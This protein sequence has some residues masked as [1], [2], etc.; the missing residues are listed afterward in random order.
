MAATYP[1]LLATGFTDQGR[2]DPFDLYGGESDI[3]T[4][5]GQA[6]DGQ[7]IRQFEVLMRNADGKL[8]PFTTA[9]V[10]A[11]GAITVGG[12]PTAADTVTINGV[13]ITFRTTLTGT[14]DECLIGADTTATAANLVTVINNG[15]TRFNVSASSVGTVVTLVAE[16]VG[17]AGNSV[18]LV[19]GVTSIGFTVSGATLTGASATEGTLTNNAIGIAGQPVGASTPGG[20]FPYFTGGV[21]NHQ[22]LLWPAGFISLEERKRC[23]DGTNIGVRQVL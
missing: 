11:T 10:Y 5:Q 4:D 9:G 2:F 23:F 8:V 15:I 3:V 14:G 19:E 21:F 16:D 22:A 12:Q 13:A 6:A 7:A 20:W 18:T 17:V 1:P